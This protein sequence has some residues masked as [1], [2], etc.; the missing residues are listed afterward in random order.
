MAMSGNCWW[1]S[2]FTTT[3]SPT[4]TAILGHNLPAL[5]VIE[6]QAQPFLAMVRDQVDLLIANRKPDYSFPLTV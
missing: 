3:D 2:I 5:T 4:G 6:E 1:Y